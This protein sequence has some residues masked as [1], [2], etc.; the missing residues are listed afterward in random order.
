MYLSIFLSCMYFFHLSAGCNLGGGDGCAR[1]LLNFIV[2][3]RTCLQIE[4]QHILHFD[5]GHVL[6]YPSC[7]KSPL[8]NIQLRPCC[9]KIKISAIA[10]PIV[11]CEFAGCDLDLSQR[12]FWQFSFIKH[13]KYGINLDIVIVVIFYFS[14]GSGGG[15]GY[16]LFRILEILASK[17]NLQLKKMPI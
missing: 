4:T 15:S 12:V 17:R 9:G 3:L 5:Q 13:K 16:R 8:K 2:C 11:S 10:N 6:Y 7:Y 1:P 14:R